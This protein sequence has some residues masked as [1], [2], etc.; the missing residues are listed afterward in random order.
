M[1][2]VHFSL[3]WFLLVCIAVGTV[4]KAALGAPV[5]TPPH[6][7]GRPYREPVDTE[8]RRNAI[9]NALNLPKGNTG[10]IPPPEM[11]KIDDTDDVSNILKRMHELAVQAAS[12]MP[13]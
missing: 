1:S 3:F 5:G 8:A 4:P 12:E 6:I 13:P 9:R 10:I 7:C 11:E 2:L